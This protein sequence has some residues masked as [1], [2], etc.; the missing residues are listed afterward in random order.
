MYFPRKLIKA[1]A[2]LLFILIFLSSCSKKASI[3]TDITLA[4]TTIE[5][6]KSS[7]TS[8]TTI[9]ETTETTTAETTFFEAEKPESEGA[10]NPITGEMTM[11]KANIGKRSFTVVINNAKAAIPSR[12][13]TSADAIYEYETEGGQ[14]RL[15]AL[16]ADVN[17]IPEIGSLRSA[18]I[19]ATDLSAGTNSIFVH[20][21]ENKRVPA[22]ISEIGLSHI[23]GNVMSRNSGKSDENG[24]IELPANFYFWRD[25]DWKAKRALEHTAV[26][27]GSYLLKAAQE[28]NVGWEGETPP[29]FPFSDDA[30]NILAK[31]EGCKELIIRFSSTNPDSTFTYDPDSKSYFKS[32]YGS[33]QIDET[34]EEQISVKNI[35]VLFT[36]ITSHGDTTIDVWLSEGG[37][38]YYA[39]EE[40]IIPITW[41]KA[42][43]NAPIVIADENGTPIPVLPGKS[44][45]N[46]VR[47][48]AAEQ[49]KWSA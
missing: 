48:T 12:G 44:Y 14:T 41:T 10:L 45:I 13:V 6:E 4:E 31:G 11:D 37:Q 16:F 8:E 40:K 38:G 23:D 33:P 17:M 26:S 36:K 29:L 2:F 3:N 22:H 15:L 49:T 9:P 39:S 25:D 24:M 19:I 28:R 7:T 34:T 35:L 30:N 27:N 32:E 18:R 47:N 43:S 42:D 21:G 46:I 1:T 20:Y 5:T